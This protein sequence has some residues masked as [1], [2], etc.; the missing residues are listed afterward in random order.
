M[1]GRPDAGGRLRITVIPGIGIPHTSGF[2]YVEPSEEDAFMKADE[3]DE[4][5]KDPTG[6]L[7]NVWLP[8][9]STEVAKIGQPATYRNNIALVKSAMA[10]LSYFYAFGPQVARMRTECGTASA[11]SGIFKAPFD[12][13]RTSCAATLA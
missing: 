12:I 2:N 11:I 7:Y 9:V 8:R 4:L 6:F 5:I 1:C 10:M 3:Y 13:I